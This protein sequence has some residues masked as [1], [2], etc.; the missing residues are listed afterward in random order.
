MKILLTG[1]TG[2]IGKRILPALLEKG[3]EV[4]C[5]VRDKDR[6]DIKKYKPGQVTVVE[7]DLAK[8]WTFGRSI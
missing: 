1:S 2:Y 7:A 3:H 5:M 4:V 8:P 6:L